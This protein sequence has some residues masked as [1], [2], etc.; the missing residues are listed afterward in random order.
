M[1]LSGNYLSLM[2]DPLHH[3]STMTASGTIPSGHICVFRET[4]WTPTHTF[5]KNA[6]KECPLMVHAL[7]QSDIVFHYSASIFYTI[8]DVPYIDAHIWYVRWTT[9]LIGLLKNE[10]HQF[11]ESENGCTLQYCTVVDIKTRNRSHTMAS[12]KYPTIQCLLRSR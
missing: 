10:A 9:H 11:S 12:K 6:R 3:R 7:Q 5:S 8:N 4:S 1:W 2:L